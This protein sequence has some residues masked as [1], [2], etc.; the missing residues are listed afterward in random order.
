M[1]TLKELAQALAND[2]NHATPVFN[3]LA[4]KTTTAY[5]DGLLVL[6][7]NQATTYTKVEVDTLLTPEA[8]KADVDI[9]LASKANLSEMLIALS[10]KHPTITSTTDIIVSKIITKSVEPPVGTTIVQ[11]RT[12]NVMFGIAM[13]ASITSTKQASGLRFTYRKVLRPMRD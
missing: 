13:Y 6:N 7:A 2:P 8:T 12:N 1:N 9:A 4:T 5:V 3:Q 11:L 10:Q